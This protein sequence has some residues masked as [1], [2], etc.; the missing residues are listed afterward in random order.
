M[1]KLGRLALASL[2][3]A[4]GGMGAAGPAKASPASAVNVTPPAIE[5]GEAATP[6][7]HRHRACWPKYRWV[8][9]Y[10]GWRYAYVGMRCRPRHRWH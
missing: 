5:A 7:Y 2:F 6:V 4:A 9:T 3:A 1:S 8:W 10:W